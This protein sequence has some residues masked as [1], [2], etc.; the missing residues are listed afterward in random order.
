MTD[1][2]EDPDM[3]NTD[4]TPFMDA[5]V[6]G[7]RKATRQWWESAAV[8]V[9][10]LALLV[11]LV[12]VTDVSA[13]TR[14]APAAPL[15]VRVAPVARASG[16]T[17]H[18]AELRIWRSHYKGRCGAGTFRRCNY[19][20]IPAVVGRTHSG[21][22]RFLD[23][24]YQEWRWSILHPV[25]HLYACKITGYYAPGHDLAIDSKKCYRV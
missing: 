4:D 16:M 2:T 22:W 13:S 10:V 21:W 9:I 18:E 6:R 5:Y 1:P 3:R 15:V 8:F 14:A 12:V 17:A 23:G 19:T 24:Y 20:G 7:T 11:L 25:P